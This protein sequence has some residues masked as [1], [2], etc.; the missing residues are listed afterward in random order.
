MSTDPAR[1]RVADTPQGHIEELPE[2]PP[3]QPG[4]PSDPGADGSRGDSGGDGNPEPNPNAAD[5]IPNPD[6]NAEADGEAQV[7]RLLAALEQLA[8]NATGGNR[9][10]TSKANLWDPDQFDGSDPKKLR[11]FLL[12]CKLNFRAKLESFREN[13]AKVNYVLS[14][15]KGMAV[16]YFE[17]FLIVDPE[18]K[19]GWL[20]NFKYF[21]KELYIYFGL[22][23]QHAEAKIELKQLVMNFMM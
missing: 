5:P 4:D 8:D 7:G 6:P 13:S 17:P 14:F 12:Q 3:E 21:T 22:Y 19:P 20:M 11:G 16:D 23:D 1:Q 18:Y 9:L 15:L 10:T 2:D